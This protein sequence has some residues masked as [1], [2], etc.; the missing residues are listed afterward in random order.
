[1]IDVDDLTAF[2][3]RCGA[4]QWRG[5]ANAIGDTVPLDDLLAQAREVAGHRGIVVEADDEWL[6]ARDVQHWMGPRSIPLW[7]PRDMPGFATRSNTAYRAAGGRL[8]GIRDT[9][10]RTLADER[11]RGLDRER[12]AGLTRAEELAL[13]AELST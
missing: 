9:L 4:E 12:R 1:M 8:R 7:L 3:V 2:L 5:V 11:A 6:V 10:E 13:L